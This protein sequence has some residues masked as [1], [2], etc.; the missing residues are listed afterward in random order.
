MRSIS[1]WCLWIL[2][3]V[4]LALPRG[5]D[6]QA[7]QRPDAPTPAEREQQLQEVNG[8]RVGAIL[9]Q[10]ALDFDLSHD[11]NV[12]AS[13]ADRRA[14]IV[15][16]VTPRLSAR[17]FS[18]NR[19]LRAE[20]YYT[21]RTYADNASE[22]VEQFGGL[23]A[24]DF[25]VTRGLRASASANARSLTEAR[26][27]IDSNRESAKPVRFSD[28][29]TR[30]GLA[31]GTG[32]LSLDAGGRVRRL[33]YGDATIG[34]QKV[35]QGFRNA[36]IAA[37]GFGTGYQI[38]DLTRIVTKFEYETRRYDLSA[39]DQGFD[40]VM[41]FDRSANGLRIEAGLQ[42]NLSALVAG[43]VRVG[44]L[45]LDYADSRLLDVGAVSYFGDLRWNMTPLT[46]VTLSA[47][48]RLDETISPQSAGNLRDE[49]KVRLDH[50]LLRTLFISGSASQSWIDPVGD[51]FGSKELF[52]DIS[53]RYYF[54][55]RFRLE[56]GYQHSRRSSRNADIAYRGNVLMLGL[57]I[58]P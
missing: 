58:L 45:K 30:L 40:P 27:G 36:T 1:L 7:V 2:S 35:D 56:M 41:N 42:R 53:A 4:S 18:G 55:R 37:A 29:E 13:S 46:T 39:G 8:A 23:V 51:V 11:D 14:D 24:T 19:N 26:R 16:E 21:R 15:A 9:I 6:A 12:F 25:V 33:A 50:E 28:L 5:A 17:S 43:T 52:I 38:R 10:P 34:G 57:S 48:R 22:S 49:V 31:Y 32:R 47:A 3:T 44:Y 54:G 20:A